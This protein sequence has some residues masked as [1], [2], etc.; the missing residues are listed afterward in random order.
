MVDNPKKAMKKD[1]ADFLKHFDTLVGGEEKGL[2]EEDMAAYSEYRSPLAEHLN[3]MFL[4]FE[5]D[6]RLTE[7]R[8]IED[9]RQY[10]GEYSPKIR[11][12]LHP[13]RSKAFLSLTRTKVKTVSA[14]MTDLLFPANGER[15]FS[16]KPTPIPELNPAIV[17]SI[18]YQFQEQTGEEIDEETAKKFI[19]EEADKRAEA[20]EEE[21][22]DQ[23]S[24]LRYRYIIRNA[25]KDGNI[26]GTGI[27]K[28]PLTQTLDSTRY[29][30]HG[31][32]WVPIKLK[33]MLPFCEHV[34]VWD[35]YPDMSAR[36]PEDVRGIFQRYVMTRHKVFKLAQRP[37]FNGNAIKAYLS[38][39]KHGDAE[40]KPFEQD[41]KNLNDASEQ[42]TA[43]VSRKDRYELRE[44]WGYMST[45]DL[46]EAGLEID[47][48]A[49]G[50]EV[51]ANIWMLGP[52]I[53]KAI[54]SPIEGVNLP[55]HFYYYDKD[56]TS[57]WGEGIPTIMR[58]AQSLFNASVRAMLDN[59]AISAGPII[60]ANIDLLDPNEKPKNLF[61]FRVYLRDG[62]GQEA[63]APAIRVYTMPSYTNEFMNM[64]QFFMTAADEVTAVPRYM[65]GDTQQIGGAGKTATGLSMLMG[66]ANVTLKDQIK[67]FDDGITVP[68]IKALY[69]WNMEFNP[70]EHIKGDFNTV[71]RGST[72]LIAREVKAE[73][74][75]QFMTVTQ[76]EV[77]M[78]YTKRDNV[79]RE[80][81]KV[82]DLDELDLVKGRNEVA[83]EERQRAAAQDED[84]KFMKELAYLKAT[85][86][87]HVN[88]N[89]AAR[90]QM[91]Q[92][93][94][95]EL[96]GGE[97]PAVQMG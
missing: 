78:V 42:D 22:A 66:A 57:I 29:L 52:M 5:R 85:S 36:K 83:I 2:T 45:N 43:V 38:V 56:D 17:D 53:I 64:I 70:K 72:S 26:Y 23:L 24:E 35:V 11:A 88:Q 30:A 40:Y 1:A 31:D 71:A 55:Y 86:G 9:L 61:P 82:L 96:E 21:M 80:Y 46:Q 15:N 77:D 12:R 76:N 3:G 4:E 16:I 92:L 34:S 91:E 63:A 51:A 73:S 97:I 18:R 10:R 6:R 81:A 49:L 7:E 14:R 94:S 41:L 60:E 74:L 62:T 19:N 90:P 13:N 59:A 32:E 44:F 95:E 58:D 67:N 93:S 48:D 47:E 75:M 27:L 54:I 79:L 68:F 65:Y 25:I 69:F 28:G 20:M 33:K 89:P 37:D 8:W 50:M 84:E 39:H 87:G